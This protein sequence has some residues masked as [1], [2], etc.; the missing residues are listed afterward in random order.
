MSW[1][2]DLLA[3]IG[4]GLIGGLTSG[5]MGTSPG[6]G[7]GIFWVCPAVA[8]L[9]TFLIARY[10]DPMAEYVLTPVLGYDLPYAASFLIV[11]Y[12]GMLHYY[13]EV[14]TWKQGS[15]YRQHVAMTP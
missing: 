3:G 11:G 6:G 15:P 2:H 1:I 12:L 7:L 9:L 4:V 5:F 8:V 13:T 14:F 10:A